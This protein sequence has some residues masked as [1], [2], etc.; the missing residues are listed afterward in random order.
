[1]KEKVLTTRSVYILKSV[2]NKKLKKLMNSVQL[3]GRIYARVQCCQTSLRSL[4]MKFMTSQK[5][6]II[7]P[8]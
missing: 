7:P 4:K 8:Q 2:Q 1:M 6:L 5:L 3:L